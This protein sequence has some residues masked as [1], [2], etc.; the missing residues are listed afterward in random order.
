MPPTATPR[1][2]TEWRGEYYANT[3]LTNAPIVVR[4]DSDVNFNWG[5]SAPA[6]GLPVDNFS[7]RWTRQLWFAAQTYRFTAAR[8]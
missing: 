7:A 3:T 6:G 1:P 5:R 2:I 8:G 4:N